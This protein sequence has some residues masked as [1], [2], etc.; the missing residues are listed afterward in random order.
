MK[1][2][3]VLAAIAFTAI[4]CQT[5]ASC[6]SGSCPNGKCASKDCPK[7]PPGCTKPCCAKKN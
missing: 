7:C 6:P 1:H 3:L 2:L 4:G 5:T